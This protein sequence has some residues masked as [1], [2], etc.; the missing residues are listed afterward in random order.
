MLIL[1]RKYGI[2]LINGAPRSPQTQGLVEKGND[3]VEKK[4]T[5][6]K[7]DHGTNKW[8]YSLVEVALQINSQYH[9]TIGGHSFEVVFCHKKPINWLTHEERKAASG[10]ECER[11]EIISEESLSK[12]LEDEKN[13][14][15]LDNLRD[16]EILGV[17]VPAKP[18][19]GSYAKSSTPLTNDQN[20]PA[21][22]TEDI[23]EDVLAASKPAT[24]LPT[25][26]NLTNL[27]CFHLVGMPVSLRSLIL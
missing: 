1:L 27:L 6:W 12:E 11:G 7:L 22:T 18:A 16:L 19:M 9:R 15:V 26:E 25:P 17:K 23:S 5:K 3:E 10:V 2:K 13:Q 4:I 24:S 20:T 8:H 14:E 21:Q